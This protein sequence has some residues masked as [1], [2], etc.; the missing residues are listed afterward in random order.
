M[1]N[2]IYKSYFFILNI[3]ARFKI[4]IL[5][6]FA[7]YLSIF[8]LKNIK[9]INHTKNKVLI[10]E[11]SIG[12]EDLRVSFQ[13][14]EIKFIPY[15]LQRRTLFIIHKI[16]FKKKYSDT[17]YYSEKNN[18][19]II[20]QKHEKYL[21]DI[22]YYLKKFFDFR[23]VIS[24]N[25]AYRIDSE[26]GKCCKILGIKYIVCQKESNFLEGERKVLVNALNDKS[27]SISH[28]YADLM[29][30]YSV[31]YRDLLIKNKIIERKKTFLTGV[32]RIDRLYKFKE[33]K[34]NKKILIM[35]MQ[36]LRTQAKRNYKAVN[37]WKELSVDMIRS[38]IEIARENPQQE[39]LF[40]TKIS[41]EV[42]SLNQRK[43]I[44]TANLNNLKI[45][46]GGSS[47]DFIEK[48]KC[49][50]GFNSTCLLEGIAAKKIVLVPYFG[51]NKDKFKKDFTMY[52][53]DGVLLSHN[54]SQF[55]RYLN[56]IIKNKIKIRKKISPNQ[57][58]LMN[59]HVYNSDGN[60]SSRMTQIL[61][62]FI[63][64]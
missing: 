11:K 47:L 7:I 22:I 1:K 4:P 45:I 34:T 46:Y 37:F 6:A 62:S 52:L 32:P 36:V 24:F 5:T 41:N 15:V 27:K 20:K 51:I 2:L 10:L 42:F 33:K 16:F 39:F 56:Q 53:N 18:I 23:A 29:T 61:N 12:I 17:Q 57:K 43:I 21:S 9:K 19:K 63:C 13:N 35:L 8:K 60:A 55:K 49:V 40:K 50:I 59:M 28:C 25:Y 3:I 38:I 26:F 44:Q 48:S 54:K 30:L 14:S 58:K 31:R 64:D